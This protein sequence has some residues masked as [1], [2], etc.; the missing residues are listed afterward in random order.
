M[1]LVRT[2]GH[3]VSE[4][5]FLLAVC[6]GVVAKSLNFLCVFSALSWGTP[7]AHCT[8]FWPENTK[9]LHSGSESLVTAWLSHLI[10]VCLTFSSF[11]M[12]L[13]IICIDH[14]KKDVTVNLEV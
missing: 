14:L 11:K 1:L 9:T 12:G 5:G 3:P 2:G 7:I 13:E 8:Q 10:S 4:A 6:V